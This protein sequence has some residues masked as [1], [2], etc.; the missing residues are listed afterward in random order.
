MVVGVSIDKDCR[1]AVD[2]GG[3]VIV[4]VGVVVD[5]SRTFNSPL[6][7]SVMITSY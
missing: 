7:A 3:D 6:D 1:V 2:V 5:T 4:V